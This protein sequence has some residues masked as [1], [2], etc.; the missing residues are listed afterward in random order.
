MSESKLS[1]EQLNEIL[2]LFIKENKKG[3]C[4][5]EIIEIENSPKNKIHEYK[6]I[7]GMIDN[8]VNEE[9]KGGSIIELPYKILK[10]IFEIFA[11]HP[12]I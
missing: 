7:G 8:L 10:K 12:V 2:S 5:E 9:L 3:G 11:K 1:K 6:K 4:E